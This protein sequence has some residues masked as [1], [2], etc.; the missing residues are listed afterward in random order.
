MPVD[1]RHG[2]KTEELAARGPRGAFE[3]GEAPG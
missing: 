2:H 3:A 1:S